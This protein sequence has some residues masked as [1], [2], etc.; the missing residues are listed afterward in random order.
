MSNQRK[1]LVGQVVKSGTE[2]TV[3]VRVDRT[4]R[5]RLYQKVMR[6]K[7]KYLVHDEQGCQVGDR[8]KIVESRPISKRKRWA[9]EEIVQ[10][11]EVSA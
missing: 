7:K 8:V 11:A 6:S 3:T 1:R 4:Y 9:V 5:H 2:K 10:R